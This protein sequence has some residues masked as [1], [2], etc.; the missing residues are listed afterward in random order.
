MRL[1]MTV[2]SVFFVVAAAVDVR[3]PLCDSL[4]TV[5]YHFMI[6]DYILKLS[7]LCCSPNT[8]QQTYF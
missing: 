8:L 5:D 1:S 3:H 6:S 7:A 4:Q 2:S